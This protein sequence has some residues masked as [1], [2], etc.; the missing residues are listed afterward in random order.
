MVNASSGVT[1]TPSALSP[2]S[3]RVFAA[4][5]IA[6]TV[7]NFGTWIQDVGRAWLMTD[8]TPSATLVALVQ[9]ASMA[10]T[11]L[12]VLPAGVVADLYDRRRVLLYSQI[13]MF[14]V[15]VV[16]GV[17]TMLGVMTP[18]LLLLLTFALTAGASFAMPA[19]QAMIADIVGDKDLTQALVLNGISFNLARAVGPA[20]G[21]V[22]VAAMGSGPVFLLNAAS[23]AGVIA[24]IFFYKP[25]APS[26][27]SSTPL[28]RERAIDALRA[29]VRYATNSPDMRGVLGRIAAF[30]IPAGALWSLLPLI[31]RRDPDAGPEFYGLLLA[32]VG[33]G[34][35][36]TGIALPYL[37]RLL[38]DAQLAS[39]AGGLLGLS[40]ILVAATPTLVLPVMVIAGVGWMV[41]MALLMT[42]VQ[43]S[44]PGWVRG[45][46]TALFMMIFAFGMGVGSVIWGQLA[47]VFDLSTSLMAAGALQLVAA[48]LTAGLRLPGAKTKSAS[49]TNAT[50][51]HPTIAGNIDPQHGPIFVTIHYFVRDEAI[52]RFKEIMTEIARTRRASGTIS[53]QLFE[54]GA[55]PGHFIETNLVGTW[56]DHLRQRA[57]QSDEAQSLEA[58]L[59]QTFQTDREPQ[60]VHWMGTDQERDR[61]PIAE[62]PILMGPTALD[63]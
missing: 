2:L 12:L 59:R 10:A 26:T 40:L 27:E 47:D 32:A 25:E 24:V 48:G 52:A 5:F 6:T 7:S 58:D 22:L 31:A 20:I 36:L 15:S 54:H 43:V 49:T 8:L 18:A 3:N 21:G 34:S 45:R 46:A 55:E 17:S 23:F 37:R 62:G 29:G 38:T 4:L 57:R 13:W 39:T 30:S 28:G 9:G 61:T 44:V 11:V 51:P 16:L 63:A 33:A 42:G 53:W 19:F 41:S 14:L 56:D 50:W 60:V 1:A 35:V